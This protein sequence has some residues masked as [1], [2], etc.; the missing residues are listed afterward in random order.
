M[1][2]AGLPG[3]RAS[4]KDANYAGI[5][6]TFLNVVIV[7][8]MVIVVIVVIVELILICC[9]ISFHVCAPEWKKLF[10]GNSRFYLGLFRSKLFLVE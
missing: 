6:L 1:I 3:D 2:I 5:P 10:L 7:V 8:I 9:G 4:G